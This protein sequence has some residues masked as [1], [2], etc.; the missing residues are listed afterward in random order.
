MTLEEL[1]KEYV[2]EV[3]KH[4][5]YSEMEN[6]ITERMVE[7]LED[8]TEGEILDEIDISSFSDLSETYREEQDAIRLKDEKRGL[9]ADK[10]DV[11]N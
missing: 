9:Y 6:F 8:M 4:M 1:I 5:D 10:I 7:A 11:S 2:A 3:V